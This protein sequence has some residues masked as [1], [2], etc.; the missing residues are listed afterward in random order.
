LPPVR[1]LRDGRILEHA[2]PLKPTARPEAKQ[3]YH[4]SETELTEVRTQITTLVNQGWIRPSLSPWGAP[5]LFQRKK[6]GK[7]RMCIDYRALNHHTVKHVYPMP[8]IEELLQKL[9]AYTVVS[10]LDLK[11]GYHQIRMVGSDAPKT[12]FVT[13]YGAFEFLVMP[14]GLSNAPAV[15]TLMMNDALGD[16][17]Y[18]L[19]F[20]D[21]M[22][23]FSATISE[24]HRHLHEV[25]QRLRQETLRSPR[26]VR[27][28]PHCLGVPEHLVTSSGLSALPSK[29]EAVASWPPPRQVED[30]RQFLGLT[31]FYRHFTQN[32]ATIA[33]PLTDHLGPQPWQWSSRENQAFEGLKVALTNAPVLAFTDSTKPFVVGTDASDFAIRVVLQQ[34]HG[35]GLQPIAFLSRKLTPHQVKYP[36]L[37]KELFAIIEALCVWRHHLQ[38]AAFTVQVLTDHVTLKYFSKQPKLSPRQVRWSELLTDLDLKIEYKPGRL[39]IV[40]DALSRRPDLKMLLFSALVDVAHTLRSDYTH[41]HGLPPGS[42]RLPP[43]QDYLPCE[44][45]VPRHGW[46]PVSH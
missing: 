12:T 22:L 13:Q 25:L 26:Q 44:P 30:L 2:I 21:D 3:P 20:M 19:L 4:L 15:F 28:L 14:F 40:P 8:R 9:R 38:G 43:D 41:P 18:A 6:D 23:V 32:Y 33:A 31:G 35:K 5:V 39:N 16:L 45:R 29:I 36:V 46:P 34:D 1:R 37:E 42:H 7:L 10:K 11:S 17:P 24:H 27:V